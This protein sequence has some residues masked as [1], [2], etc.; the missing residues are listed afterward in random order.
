MADVVRNMMIKFYM[1][2]HSLENSLKHV[3]SLLQLAMK[4][5]LKLD[6]V[7]RDEI[8]VTIISNFP[9]FLEGMSDD[10]TTTLMLMASNIDSDVSPA[11]ID[12]PEDG[13]RAG[14]FLK[15]FWKKAL[16]GKILFVNDHLLRSITRNWL[17]T[18]LLESEK[19]ES[20]LPKSDMSN[21]SVPMSVDNV[22][23]K[24]IVVLADIYM[25]DAIV[26][27]GSVKPTVSKESIDPTASVPTESDVDIPIYTPK[28]ALE[29]LETVEYFA[30]QPTEFVPIPSKILTPKSVAPDDDDLLLTE[31]TKK[32]GDS[33]MAVVH[34]V[35]QSVVETAHPELTSFKI[36]DTQNILTSSQP[37]ISKTSHSVSTTPIDESPK[38]DSR[39][40]KRK[41]APEKFLV[42]LTSEPVIAASSKKK[43]KTSVSESADPP[44]QQV[45]KTLRSF[46]KGK[47]P[48]A[49]PPVPKG[50]K[51]KVSSKSRGR[52]LTSK[53]PESP[54]SYVYT[55]I[56]VDTETKEK[57]PSMIKRELI[58]QRSVDVKQLNSVCD[59]VPL[60][61]ELGLMSTVQ[62]V[63]PYSKLLTCEFLC[64]LSEFIDDLT[65]ERCLQIFVRGK[66]F[67][68]GSDAINEYYGLPIVDKDE[69]D[70]WDLV[71]K[72]L[73]GGVLTEWPSS[74]ADALS[75][76]DFTSKFVIL[77]RIALHNWLP[78]A[79]FYVV[80]K[81]LAA[82]IFWI[83]TKKVVDLGK[84]I[85]DHMLTLIHPREQKV[86]LPY[87]NLVFGMLTYQGL[88]PM[89]NEVVRT[90]LYYTVYSRLLGGKNIR[91]V[92]PV[93]LPQGVSSDLADPTPYVNDLRL[94]K[95]LKVHVDELQTASTIINT[96]L[97]A[98]RTELAT[99]LLRLSLSKVE[100]MP[101][102][103]Q[104]AGEEGSYDN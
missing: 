86:K 91:D 29:S 27:D 55:L 82:L 48:A 35:N 9:E 45:F 93:E 31:L 99:I 14:A 8:I 11:T 26:S 102:S 59:V 84:W 22:T 21:K 43:R 15:Y 12:D 70:D 95:I 57:W 103:T 104:A 97:H 85:F 17:M 72:T 88:V 51:A 61:E 39:K 18:S 23:S 89:T 92:K 36:R 16:N 63:G 96:Q 77:H 41:G 2:D 68:F 53:V 74:D 33:V 32:M 10:D 75:S 49:P 24:Q 78:S 98:A 64:N 73:T 100:L 5:K 58:V 62:K 19:V 7:L 79:H 69:I 67:V 52:S 34:E 50:K 3:K 40:S 71:A 46:V 37:T 6:P 60:L 20:D 44:V 101:D 54:D 38:R 94:S 66:W 30:N 25:P 47:G 42:D 56:F 87:P 90:T 76:S 1:N 28:A 83:G 81:S 80:S 65:H 4:N 13:N